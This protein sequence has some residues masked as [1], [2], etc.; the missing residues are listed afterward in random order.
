MSITARGKSKKKRVAS[1]SEVDRKLLRLLDERSKD[2]DF[3]S[4]KERDRS[5]SAHRIFQY[6]AMMVPVV[7]RR[8]LQAVLE[9]CP[10]LSSLYDPYVGS[11]TSLVSGMHYGLAT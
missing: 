1:P 7:Q 3:W 10:D 6:P 9:A 5:D 11:G 8:L 2:E 4:S